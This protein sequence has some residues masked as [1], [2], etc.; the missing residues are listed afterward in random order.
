M[1]ASPDFD[2]AQLADLASV[3]PTPVVR[4]LAASFRSMV[5][6]LLAA[7]AE[8]EGD[9]AGLREQAHDLKSTAGSFGARHLQDMAEALEHASARG[10]PVDLKPLL[11]QMHESASAAFAALDVALA[12]LP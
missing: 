12:E 7:V 5:E 1:S 10:E 8:T 3:L 11:A 4:D 9:A 6:A 2:P